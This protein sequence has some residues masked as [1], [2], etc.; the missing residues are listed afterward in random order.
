MKITVLVPTKMEAKYFDLPPTVKIATAGI[1][2]TMS[3]YNTLK[4]IQEHRPDIIIMAGIAGVYT[5]SPY[6][7]GDTVLVSHEREADLGFFYPNEFRKLSD[8]KLDMGVVIQDFYECP[9]LEKQMPLPVAKSNTMNAAMADFVK[10]DDVDIENMEGAPFF[11]VCLLEGV[12]F[13][14]VRSISN[15][16]DLNRKDWDYESSIKNLATG[17]KSL[18]DYLNAKE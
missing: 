18:V 2:I 13:Y 16:V 3:A 8:S 6:K 10:I 17:V 1:G 4:T 14:E 12:R 11:E 9:Y 15:E 5:H 7:I